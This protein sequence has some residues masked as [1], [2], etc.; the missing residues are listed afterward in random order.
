MSKQITELDKKIER[1]EVRL[2]NEEIDNTMFT[3]YSCRFKEEKAVLQKELT[4][5]SN[6]ISNLQKCI[7]T[8]I[9]YSS[10]LN[11]LWT[12]AGYH[13]NQQIQFIVFVD[14]IRYNRK[15]EE[16]RTER[17]NSVFAN[18]SQLARVAG[19]EK[20]EHKDKN[21]SV[22]SLLWRIS[23]SNRSPQ[24]CHACALPDELIPQGDYK[25][26]FINLPFKKNSE[27]NRSL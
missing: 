16:S 3:K 12:S 18:I 17:L 14:G 5:S 27:F 7:D 11:S 8:A 26:N 4:N 13:Q 19:K 21:I 6:S 10:K 1:L 24:T 23:D 9:N 20:S 22:S 15:K 25:Y 2:I